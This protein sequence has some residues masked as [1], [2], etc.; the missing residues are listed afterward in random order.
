MLPRFGQRRSLLHS[1]TTCEQRVLSRSVYVD[2]FFSPT[3]TIG[4]RKLSWSGILGGK[5]QDGVQL[6]PTCELQAQA[7]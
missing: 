6:R 7:V 5:R 1:V 3:C 4:F 2:S